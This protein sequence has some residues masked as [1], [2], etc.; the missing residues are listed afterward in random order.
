MTDKKIGFG[1]TGSFCTFRQILGIIK[2][3]AD[4][5]NDIYPIFSFSVGY[6]TR[7]FA[8]ADFEKEVIAATGK[9]PIKTITEA[10][11]IG[12]QNKLD[13]M[14]IAPCTGNTLAKLSNGITD[15]PVLMAAKA[16]LRNNKPLLIAVSS[17]DALSANHKNIAELMNRKNIYFVPF[18]QDDHVKKINS[19]IADYNLIEQAAESALSGVQLQPVLK[20]G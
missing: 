8:A 11:P 3:L 5:P 7:F 4:K 1:I 17:N 16:H 10:E 2:E 6:D 9:T 12:P 20:K 13:I 14:I 18:T 19:L 15:T